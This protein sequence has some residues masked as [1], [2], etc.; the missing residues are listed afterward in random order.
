MERGLWVG[1]RPE[2]ARATGEAW[3]RGGEGRAERGG[4]AGAG[5]TLYFL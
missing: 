3:A 1:G 2:K 5:E 4:A